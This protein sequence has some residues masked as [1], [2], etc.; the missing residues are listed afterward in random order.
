MRTVSEEEEEDAKVID[1]VYVIISPPSGRLREENI[2]Q[3]LTSMGM[4]ENKGLRSC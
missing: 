1:D 4:M 2:Q 3:K